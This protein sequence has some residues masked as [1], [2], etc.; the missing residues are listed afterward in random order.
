MNLVVFAAFDDDKKH[1]ERK[2]CLHVEKIIFISV[3]GWMAYNNS[4][5]YI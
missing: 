4:A 1:E 2:K 3:Y 5:I